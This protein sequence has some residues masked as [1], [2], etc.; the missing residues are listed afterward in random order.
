MS[1]SQKQGP[2]D[3]NGLSKNDQKRILKK[4]TQSTL[5]HIKQKKDVSPYFMSI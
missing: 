2:L 4:Q 3:A 1:K 5:D